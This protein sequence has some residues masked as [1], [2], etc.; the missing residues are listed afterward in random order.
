MQ[1]GDFGGGFG[2]VIHGHRRRKGEKPG[3]AST[4]LPVYVCVCARVG[5]HTSSATL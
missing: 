5:Y 2:M 1:F 4:G 3:L